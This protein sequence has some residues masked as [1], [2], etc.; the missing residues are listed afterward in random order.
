[1]IS[2]REPGAWERRP[3]DE[4]TR[5]SF[6][7]RSLGVTAA[8]AGLAS[9][10]PLV[11]GAA[12]HSSARAGP[13]TTAAAST[14]CALTPD[15]LRAYR[16]NGSGQSWSKISGVPIIRLYGGQL[17]LLA[18]MPPHGDV[19]RLR[20]A[21]ENPDGRGA[22][23][24]RIGG[25]GASFVVTG[26]GIYGLTPTRNG[27]WRYDG[28]GTSWTQVGSAAS[29]IFGGTWGLVANDPTTGAL[30]HYLGSPHRWEQIGV[31]GATFAVTDESVYGVTPDHNR[32]YRYDGHGT[33]W[34]RI[35]D[36]TGQLYGG[37][38]G[39]VV[40]D[41]GGNVYRYLGSPHAW[42]HI[43]GPGASFAVAHDTVYG[44]NPWRSGVYRYSGS[45]TFW[46][47]AGGP[48]D[49]IVASARVFASSPGS[50]HPI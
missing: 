28:T 14:C 18:T 15:R 46:T 25:P 9:G 29:R 26:E 3:G 1:M 23:W 41:R 32:L 21:F 24:D 39:L 6:L 49:S 37:D 2:S 38:W 42:Q 8:A 30:F 11:P 27:V 7:A 34:T 33:S 22:I 17:G 40:T 45:G 20:M 47:E 19:F 4:T 12:E 10:I 50:V 44:L 35:G 36:W 31:E 16:Y 43:G 5:R 48:A 13:L